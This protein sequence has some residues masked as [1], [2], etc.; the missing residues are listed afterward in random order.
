M[1]VT[2]I[3]GSPRKEGNTATIVKKLAEQ[4]KD[5]M[6][7]EIIYLSDHK[8]NGCTGCSHCQGV[9]EDLGCIKDDDIDKLLRKILI[10]D[11]VIYCTPLYGHSYSGQLKL[12]LDRHVALFKFIEGKSN[13]VDKMEIHSFIEDK[14]IGLLVSCQGPEEDNTELIKAQF[15]KLCESSLARCLGKYIFPLCSPE[16]YNSSYSDDTLRKIQ[17]DIL[18]I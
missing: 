1:K 18:S 3:I 6:N 14:K 7:C 12:F 16:K 8:L 9:M 5:N 17:N 2:F 11:A 10:S 13:S 4:L 15:D